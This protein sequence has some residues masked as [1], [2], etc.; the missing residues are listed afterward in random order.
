MGKFKFFDE[1]DEQYEYFSVEEVR[2][3]KVFLA[4]CM[5]VGFLTILFMTSW[6]FLT[7]VD[8]IFA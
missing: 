7:V 1:R 2:V 6:L 3:L 8:Y 4:V 5:I